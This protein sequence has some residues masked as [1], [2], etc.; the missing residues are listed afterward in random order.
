MI[1]FRINNYRILIYFG[2]QFFR[3]IYNLIDRSNNPFKPRT[4]I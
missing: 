4:I 3:E 2:D 1:I